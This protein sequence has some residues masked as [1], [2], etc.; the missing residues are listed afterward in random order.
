MGGALAVVVLPALANGGGNGSLIPP[1]SG[2][3]ITPT[4]FSMGGKTTDCT[5]FKSTA[6]SS[7]QITSPKTQTYST[8]VNG[9]PVTFA[10]T[11]STDKKT[12]DFTS[13]GA[14]VY[15]VSAAPSS[16][17][18]KDDDDPTGTARYQY[19]KAAIGPVT[20]DTA[21]HTTKSK[22]G[23]LHIVSRVTFCFASA[24]TVSGTVVNDAN[25]NGSKDASETG[26][27]GWTLNLYKSGTTTP[28][29]P[30]ATTVAGG[31]YTFTNVPVGSAYT[32][33]LV[34]P[35]GWKQTFPSTAT[36]PC[37]S[38]AGENSAGV[39]VPTLV[40]NQ[41]GLNF[42]IVQL[43]S[44][45]GTAF[46][47]VNDNGL[48]DNGDSPQAGANVSLYQTGGS[49]PLQSTQTLA[50]GTYQFANVPVVTQ[51]YTVC[52]TSLGSNWAQTLP[53]ATTTGKV[54]CH[55]GEFPLG[56][57]IA[58]TAA[59]V[60]G[61]DFGSVQL[62]SISGSA[63]IDANDNAA[64]DSGEVGQAAG[65]V[66]LYDSSGNLLDTATPDSTT[67]AYTFGKLQ[68]VGLTYKVCET[69]PS[70]GTWGQTL[71]G[72]STASCGS[73]EFPLGLQFVLP[74]GG[75]G[76]LALDLGSAP[77][78][79]G[80][81]A[82]FGIDSGYQAQLPCE[83]TKVGQSFIYAYSDG[84]TK[85]AILQPVTTSESFVPDAEKITWSFTGNVQN[86]L[87]VVYNDTPPY[88]GPKR[89]LLYCQLDPRSAISDLTLASPY[90]TYGA[91]GSGN[92]SDLVLPSGETS[93]LIS[94]TELVDGSGA[95]K[96]VAYVYSSLDG[97]RGTG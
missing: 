57:G 50:N 13:T 74:T 87:K 88:T 97:Y 27:A 55:S 92:G 48:N 54:S 23:V 66:N 71:P 93:C 61:L 15:D 14:A 8:T 24:A 47:D 21:L 70:S 29:A 75:T 96:F 17:D 80:S 35:T 3:G 37:G 68:P 2:K 43:G 22:S 59:G 39:A 90:D 86:P 11:V 51:G 33:C 45:S 76:T 91:P 28:L 36:P 62:A 25:N 40:K 16:S 7:Y 32:V 95:K 30:A 69:L 4:D 9:L 38:T 60:T 65:P 77:T 83:T 1:A 18:E 44:I 49:S 53:T 6:P 84:A 63:F 78:V 10:L 31:A 42:G 41:T 19:S 79:Q 72:T 82:P 85:L 12:F 64:Q 20:S 52:E 94:T 58:L 5:L 89:D 34:T 46:V 67:G 81:C 26:Q 73:G 56:Y